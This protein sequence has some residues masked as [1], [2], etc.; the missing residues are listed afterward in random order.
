MMDNGYDAPRPAG[1]PP[2]S[3]PPHQQDP[4]AVRHRNSIT[5]IIFGGVGVV[6]GIFEL[7]RISR[8]SSLCDSGLGALA[9]AGSHA[10]AA[11]CQGA[12]ILHAGSLI[13]AIAGGL[14]ALAGVIR[15][16]TERRPPQ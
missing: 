5:M 9:Q 10:A 3:P 8:L 1:P 12:T 7:A 15:I 2:A 11:D 14:L 13:V 6:A 4:A 16:A